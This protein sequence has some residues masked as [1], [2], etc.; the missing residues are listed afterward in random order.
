M[1]KS[2]LFNSVSEIKNVIILTL[3]VGM[4]FTTSSGKKKK[5]WTENVGSCSVTIYFISLLQKYWV[6]F[7]LSEMLVGTVCHVLANPK[8]S[9]PSWQQHLS[10]SPEVTKW[11]DHVPNFPNFHLPITS[12]LLLAI[13][14]PCPAVFIADSTVLR[15]VICFF[16][17][18]VK[19]SVL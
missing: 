14:L 10:A 6:V 5:S 9:H 12:V 3:L 15:A 8:W 13:V 17:L 1:G 19:Y 16:N 18:A 4:N 2:R 7:L 11:R